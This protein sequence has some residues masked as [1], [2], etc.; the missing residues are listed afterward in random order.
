MSSYH[1]LV[2]VVKVLCWHRHGKPT[3]TQMFR[4]INPALLSPG[5]CG[6]CG[7]LNGK[8]L[9]PPSPDVFLQLHESRYWIAHACM[10]E[11]VHQISNLQWVSL[12][13]LWDFYFFFKHKAGIF[14]GPLSPLALP[15]QVQCLNSPEDIL[16]SWTFPI[17]RSG[18]IAM[19][20]IIISSQF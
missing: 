15:I 4:L 9:L 3:H 17:S 20:P 1:V 19:T 2:P 10:R 11:A 14:F 16:I 13:P 5:G 12:Q 8:I 7:W 18:L 6:M